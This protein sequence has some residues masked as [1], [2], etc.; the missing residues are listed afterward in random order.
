MIESVWHPT[1]QA[2]MEARRLDPSLAAGVYPSPTDWRD[3]WIYQL[4]VD[5]FNN[6]TAPPQ[7][8][9]DGAHP[10]FQ[11][12]TLEGVRQKLDYLKDLGVGA[13]WLSPVQKNCQYRPDSY[14]GYGIQDFLSI[15]PRLASDPDAART[16]PALVENELIALVEDAHA[17]GMY[18]I[19]DIVLNHT[20]DT[21]EYVLDDGTTAAMASWR[22]SGPYTIRWR[23]E[24]GVG[25]ADW[26]EAPADPHRDAAV[27]PAELRDNRYF[28]RQGNAFDRPSDLQEKA[29]DFF[30]LKEIV[31]EYRDPA[32]GFV[33][34]LSALIR[35][36]QYL[37]ARY[38]VDGFR[39]DTLKYLPPDTAR[40]F[41]NAIREYA[42]SIGKRNFF[43]YGEVYDEE[44]K[45]QAYVGRNTVTDDGDLVGVDAA[46]DFPLFFRLPDVAKGFRS[47]EELAG[48]YR[49]R[50]DIGRSVLS[51]HGD[52]SRYFVTFL[53]NHDQYHRIRYVDPA[54]PT[55]FDGQV[56]LALTL[57]FS[58]QGIPCVYYGTEQGLHA[59]GDSLEA[60]REALWGKPEAFD[61]DNPFY[62]TIQRLSH[63]RDSQP[64]LRYGRQYFRATSADDVH[65]TISQGGGGAVA[66][67]RILNDREVV[68]VANPS[69]T[70]R[71]GGAVIVDASLNRDGTV[72]TTV[73]SNRAG[74]EGGA[75]AVTFKPQGSVSVTYADGTGGD[76]PLLV[77]PVSLDPMEAQILTVA[78]VPPGMR[79]I[80]L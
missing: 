79:G 75:Q 23:D 65:F 63:T 43:T 40:T 2:A 46:L 9:W 73:F 59:S 51:N 72:Y 8:S 21:F 62:Q 16:N 32:T 69:T 37:I 19:F 42:L 50:R 11:G 77:L 49:R 76:G 27:W 12:G 7:A 41:G 68:V 57:L 29:G 1:I 17:L 45:I 55:R 22:D 3:V 71:F 48:M 36:Y 31:A 47:A 80:A 26:T 61:R 13:I 78:G 6:P 34:A 18:V 15:D 70:A 74:R 28:R 54:D 10:I 25:R 24:T 66:F 33:P 39:I 5:R 14:H 67:S 56:T 4:L 20:G 60:V 35:A 52:A 44:A 64:A 58:L 38:D 30:T 53:D